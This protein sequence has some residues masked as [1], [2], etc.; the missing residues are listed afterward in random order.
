[1]EGVGKL[2]ELI[3]VRTTTSTYTM[4]VVTLTDD[5]PNFHPGSVIVVDEMLFATSST[6]LVNVFLSP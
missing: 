6:Q 3:L 4:S 5:P 2:E 1:M